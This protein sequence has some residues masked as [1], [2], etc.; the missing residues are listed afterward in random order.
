MRGA[1]AFVL[2]IYLLAGIVFTGL[3]GPVRSA[4]EADFN[5]D[6]TQF[7][8]PYALLGIVVN[9]L[10]L[11]LAMPRLSRVSGI[12]LIYGSAAITIAGLVVVSQAGS[13]GLFLGGWSLIFVA[14]MF[15]ST[16]NTMS[17]KLWKDN[18]KRGVII[19]HALNSLGKALG[20]LVAGVAL[21]IGWRWSYFASAGLY[22][23]FLLIF[24]P[25]ASRLKPVLP[26]PAPRTIAG[27]AFRSP[28]FWLCSLPFGLIAGGETAFATLI[29]GYFEKFR[30]LSPTFSALMFSAHL[31]GLMSGRIVF[32]LLSDRLSA[33]AI[34]ALCLSA[35]VFVFP[36]VLADNLIVSGVCL[37]LLGLMFSAT[38]PVFFAQ[39][40]AIASDHRD[41][42][43]FG[44]V[45]GNTIGVQAC[46]AISSIIADRNYVWALYFGPF[47]LWAFGVLYF[48][49]RLSRAPEP[50]TKEE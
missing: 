25:L 48:T 24:L 3:V 15:T 12:S 9:I 33:N 16:A 27:S 38:W 11:F 4:V 31:V 8:V 30:H 35:G 40:S 28:A 29:P 14:G 21:L 26:P 19:L 23:A 49:T 2:L 17:M 45:L 5:L 1:K 47:V 41:M 46:I 34:I 36:A 20:P 32:A 42:L 18:P 44:A 10:L 50:M 39:A 13:F 22:I 43:A 37:F 6:H 7:G